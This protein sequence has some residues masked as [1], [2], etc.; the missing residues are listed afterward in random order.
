MEAQL[1]EAQTGPTIPYENY[2]S[3]LGHRPPMGIGKEIKWGK[4]PYDIVPC[5]VALESVSDMCLNPGIVAPSPVEH[6]I[7]P[8][9]HIHRS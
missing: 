4:D 3:Q 9:P 2:K 8:T 1:A 6:R 5:Y 7:I